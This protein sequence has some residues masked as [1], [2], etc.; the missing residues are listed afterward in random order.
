LTGVIIQKLSNK[1]DAGIILAFAQSKVVNF[2]YKKTALNFY[3]N[4]VP[5]LDKAINNLVNN[6]KIERNV[7]GKN[8]QLPSNLKVMQFV[9]LT[10]WNAIR[11]LLYGLFFEKKWNVAVVRNPLKF[12]NDEILNSSNFNVLPIGK[13]YN[14]Y[15]DPFYSVDGRKIRLEALDNKT[16]LG[17]IL[18]INTNN[19]S[20]QKTILKGSHFSYPYSFEYKDLEYLLPEVASHSAQYFFCADEVVGPKC[21]LKG[22]EDKRIIDATL[23]SEDRKW[24]LFFGEAGSA[25]NILNLWIADS[26]FEVFR[27]H[28]MNPIVIS[29][30]SARMAGKVLKIG[31]SLLRF[32]QNN[33]GEYGESIEIMEITKLSQE[34][35]E[36]IKIGTISIDNF[37]GPHSID[38]SHDMSEVLIDYYFSKFSILAG[39]RRIKAK[40]KKN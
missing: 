28:P 3:S 36:E 34:I 24:F 39:V 10:I 5:L 17:D 21:Y 4:S 26:P 20:N 25:G 23:V 8:Y 13:Q 16:G 1:L 7:N 9:V 33:A 32:G 35:F 2:S 37:K 30:K 6:K 29:P 12:K 18:E 15:A 11:K 14:F 22:L 31:G 27:P 19:F 38:F 40:F